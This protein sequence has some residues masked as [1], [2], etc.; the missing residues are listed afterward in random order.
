[1]AEPRRVL[2]GADWCA[3]GIWLCATKEEHE[4]PAPSGGY[5]TG[6]AP[7]RRDAPHRPWSDR[8]TGELLDDLQAWNRT[9]EELADENPDSAGQ[10]W[11]T[12]SEQGR[13]LA[14]RV[15]QELG[16][17]GWEVLYILDGRVRRVHPPG[18]WPVRTW[19]QELLGYP[20]RTLP[21][22][23]RNGAEVTPNDGPAIA[24]WPDR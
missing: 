5:W 7:P 24:R 10:A 12:W 23:L 11:R 13:D 4:A 3:A 19:K 17:D 6:A 21:P 8:L 16:T 22:G 1:M 9:W 18:S 2:I 15:Q 14:I 20:P